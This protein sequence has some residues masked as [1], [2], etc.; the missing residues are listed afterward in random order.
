MV[1]QSFQIE[2]CSKTLSGKFTELITKIYNKTKKEVVVLIDEYDKPIIS[3][4]Q[5]KNLKDFQETL[6]SFY[7]VLKK[8]DEYIKFIFLTGIS[9]FGHVSVFSK[10]NNLNDLTLIDEFN[11]ICG[12]TQV[13]LESYFIKYMKN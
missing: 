2:I 7:E 1:A 6:G 12:Y 3:N 8:N 9:K 4:L 10:L 5:N 11:S 13:E